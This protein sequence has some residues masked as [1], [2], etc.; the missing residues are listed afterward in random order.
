MLSLYEKVL[1]KEENVDDGVSDG[2]FVVEGSAV[3][4]NEIEGVLVGVNVGVGDME[5]E[6]V[7]VGVGVTLIVMLGD[8]KVVPVRLYDMVER[9]CVTLREEDKNTDGE[10]ERVTVDVS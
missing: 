3:S 6:S 8:N 1:E 7:T 10:M 2:L 9:D 5:E 4:D